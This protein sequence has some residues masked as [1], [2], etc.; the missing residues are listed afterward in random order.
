M[1]S[2]FKVGDKVHHRN[3]NMYGIFTGYDKWDTDTCYVN[4]IADDEYNDERRV[5]ISQI[6]RA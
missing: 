2:V 3:L 1:D 5:T 6:E 4:F